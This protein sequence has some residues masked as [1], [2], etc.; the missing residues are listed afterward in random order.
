MLLL[1]YLGVLK[2][3]SKYTAFLPDTYFNSLKILM[4]GDLFRSPVNYFIWDRPILR[5]QYRLDSNT[6]A[7]SILKY[8]ADMV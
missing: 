5:L 4:L 3:L 8:D 6:E 1:H 7:L 2:I